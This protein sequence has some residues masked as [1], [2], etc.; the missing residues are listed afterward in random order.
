M[1]TNNAL[2]E[3]TPVFINPEKFGITRIYRED[4]TAGQRLGYRYE[5]VGG[6]SQ[7]EVNRFTYGEVLQTLKK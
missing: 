2:E 7:A 4:K 5:V 1:D 6:M 3:N